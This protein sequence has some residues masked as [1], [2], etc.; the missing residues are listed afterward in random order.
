MN[1]LLRVLTNNQRFSAGHPEY[2]RA[3]LL[4]VVLVG[5]FCTCLIF[6]V[7]NLFFTGQT[8]IV[9]LE[10]GGA[11]FSL[12]IFLYFHKTDKV[13]SATLF[14]VLLFTAVLLGFITLSQ[15]CHN[16]LFWVSIYPP[17][18]YFMLGKKKGPILM[19]LFLAYLVLFF[20]LNRMRWEPAGFDVGYVIN[21]LSSTLALMCTIAY[22]EHSRAE[23]A[24]VLEKKN[25]ELE[26]LTVTDY[27]TGLYNRIKLDSVLSKEINK[28]MFTTYTFSLIMADLDYF[29]QIN[30][31]YGHVVGDRVLS[32]V[33]N[34]LKNNCREKDIIGRWGGEE[35]LIICPDTD[36]QEAQ[37][38]SERLLEEVAKYEYKNGRHMTISFG[39]TQC[40]KGDT[41]DSVIKRADIAMYN[42]KA[43]GRCRVE[44]I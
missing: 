41:F 22:F 21:V 12:V 31:E 33:A 7:L 11:V 43:G 27:L 9:I 8:G 3:Y 15:N 42:A 6:S 37:S 40:R 4:N 38:L 16:S 5:M 13:K 19:G 18:V 36:I 2:R 26:R 35:F 20:L 24:R 28:S 34:I 1:F 39:V 44:T 32:D 10:L 17:I 25:E 23:S 30:D 14:T 29:K